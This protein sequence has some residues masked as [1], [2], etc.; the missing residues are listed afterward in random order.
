MEKIDYIKCGSCLNVLKEVHP[1]FKVSAT[2]NP[3]VG[4]PYG[5]IYCP[6]KN[7]NRIG[8][9]T[10]YLHLLEKKLSSEIEKKPIGLG[11]ITEPYNELEKEYNLSRNTLEIIMKN[12]FPVNI[13]TKSNIALRDI[14]MFKDYSNEGLLAV[15]VSIPTADSKLSK[16]LEPNVTILELRL[17]LLQELKKNNIFAGIVLAPIIQFVNDSKK[18]LEE[19]FDCVKS[20]AGYIL[21]GVLNLD[22]PSL[23]DRMSRF[24]AEKY[25]KD[26]DAFLE[27]YRTNGIFDNSYTEEINDIL[28]NLSEKYK[29]PLFLPLEKGSSEPADINQEMLK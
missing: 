6:Y 26:K 13:F 2:L 20:S 16:T 15:S 17:N 29:V 28:E 4:C 25:P 22:T 18:E 10:D 23:K 24:M 14:N 27:L 21:P 11:S 1:L 3:Y 7:E 8:L 12:K 9:K 5:C 19:V